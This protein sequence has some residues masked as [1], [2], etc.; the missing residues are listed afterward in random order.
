MC[1]LH[2]TA[3]LIHARV[4]A[5]FR[6]NDAD[7]IHAKTLRRQ[8]IPNSRNFV[9]YLDVGFAELGK[10]RFRAGA[11]GFDAGDRLLT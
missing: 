5:T 2:Q 11:G 1:R 4:S 9:D 3:D 6:S 8:R 10:N 7:R